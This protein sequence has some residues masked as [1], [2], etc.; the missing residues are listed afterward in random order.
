MS[1]R[2]WL[3]LCVLGTA[4]IK[5][6]PPL[7]ED[8]FCEQYARIEC[9]KVAPWCSFDPTVCQPVRKEA[10]RVSAASYKTSGR[11]FNPDNTDACLKKL[12]DSY[13]G[14]PILPA[15]LKAVD[16]AC[17]RVYGGL[18]KMNDSCAAD[19]DCSGNLICD[20]G[21]CGPLKVVSSLGGCANVGERCQPDEFCT[22]DNANQLYFCVKRVQQGAPCSLSHPCAEGLRCQDVCIAKIPSGGTCTVD[23]ECAMGYCNR[24]ISP[25]TCGVGLSFSAGAPSCIAFSMISDGGTPMR[26][27]NEVTDGGTD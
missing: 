10:C 5:S 13:K 24:Y 23:D 25:R 17:A 1:T 19:F 21:H 20:K 14:I 2:A 6:D 18:A 8:S 9:G 26:G 7:T 22:N 16:D 27:S 11:T 12:E 15:T 4:C 3:V